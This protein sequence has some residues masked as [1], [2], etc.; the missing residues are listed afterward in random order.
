MTR[1]LPAIRANFLGPEKNDFKRC[2]GFL[3]INRQ[4]THNPD[5]R[6]VKK[7]KSAFDEKA[8]SP[9]LAAKDA[10]KVGHP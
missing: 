9:T 5:S 4:G 10:A 3:T 1:I 8:V 2:F 6:T 7:D